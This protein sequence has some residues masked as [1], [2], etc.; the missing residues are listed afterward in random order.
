MAKLQH[1]FVRGK[2]NKDLDERLVPNGQYRDASNVQ[3]STSEG[4][5][6]GSVENILGNTIKNIKSIGTPNVLWPA[7]FGMQQ[8]PTCI[9][10]VKDSQNEKIYWF[11]ANE[12]D[13]AVPTS[14]IVEFDQVTGIVAPVLVDVNGV[15]NFNKLSLI[16]GVNILGG[17]LFFTDNLSEPKKI[18]IETFKAGSTNFT[19]QTNVYSRQF[20]LSDVTVILKSPSVATSVLTEASLVGGNGTGVTPVATGSINFNTG[21]GGLYPKPVGTVV[22]L[23][24]APFVAPSVNFN[25]KLVRLTTFVTNIDNTVDEYEVTGTL[26]NL[27]APEQPGQ[28]TEGDL[29]IVSIDSDVPNLGVAWSMLLVEE[30][31]IFQNNFPR[32]SY[33]WKYVDGEYSTYAP[34]SEAAFIGNE[35]DYSSTNAFNKGMANFTRR[36]TLSNFEPTPDNVIAVE[37]LYKGVASTNVYNLETFK[38]A[39]GVLTSFVITTELLG[40][41]IESLQL[42][43]PWDNVPRKAKSQEVIGNRIVYGNY[44]QNQTLT[45]TTQISANQTNTAHAANLLGEKSVKSNRTYQIGVAFIDEFN[46]ESPVFTNKNAAVNISQDKSASKNVLKASVTSSAP[47]WADFYKYYIKD[48]APEYYNLVLDRFYDA[49]DGNI[50]LSFPS[51]EIN[52]IR[53]DGYIFL[54]KKHGNS[55][56]V[57]E[58]NKYKILDISN[59]APGFI[60]DLPTVVA[61]TNM[62]PVTS[63]FVL[64]NALIKFN[65]A[66]AAEIS[67]FHNAINSADSIQ[68]TKGNESTQRYNIVS[69]GATGAIDTTPSPN[70]AK[71]E[72]TLDQGIDDTDSWIAASG[73][74]APVSVILYKNINNNLPE[75][76]GRFFVKIPRNAAF[77]NNVELPSQNTGTFRIAYQT[78][79]NRLKNNMPP[80]LTVSTFSDFVAFGDTTSSRPVAAPTDGSATFTIISTRSPVPA[81]T[82]AFTF[83]NVEIGASIRFIQSGNIGEVYTV[84]NVVSTTYQRT[85]GSVNVF[86]FEQKVVTLDRVYNDQFPSVPTRMQVLNIDGTGTFVTRNSAIFE[87]EPA[88]LADLDIYYEASDALAIGGLASNVNLDWFNCYSFGNG[89]ESN[90]IRDDFNAPTIGKGVRVSSTLDVPYEEER[91]ASSL[92]FSGIFNSISGVNNT[93]QFLTAENITKDLNPTYG[94]IQKLHA[95]DTDLIALLEDKCFK[96]LANKDALFNADGSTNVTSNSNVLGQTIPFVGEYGISKNPESFASFGFRTYFVDKARGTVLRLSRDGITDIGGKDMSFYFQDKLRK[97][98]STSIGSYDVDASS[99]NVCINVPTVGSESNKTEGV[100]FKESVDGWNST[101][102]YVPEAGIS[103]NN[104]YYTFKNGELYEHSNQTR[105][106]FYGTQYDS[107]V[108]PIFNDAP[109]SIKNFKTLSYEGTE[110]WTADVTTNLQEGEVTDWKKRESLF[111]NFIKGKA[112]TLANIDTE[113]FA[114]QGLGNAGTITRNSN[115]L[116]IAIAGGI[117]SSL[118]V[119]TLSPPGGETSAPDTIYYLDGNTIAILGPCVEITA[120][121]I[122]VNIPAGATGVGNDDFIFFGKNTQ[123]NTS[124]LLGH[125]ATVKMTTTSG[126]KK[127]L[128]AVNSEV[129]ISSE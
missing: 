75:F 31:P 60:S 21:T 120:T 18:N 100:S 121:T 53:E 3:V 123:I 107:T 125:Q 93:N 23:T 42:L 52:K 99:Y 72:V 84:A 113:E 43:R 97:S 4:S 79:D 37:V 62:T 85:A 33:R 56:P 54:K 111:F 94:S 12:P 10:V 14:A 106:N 59:E 112:T 91:K 24:W 78:G 38:V 70:L 51:S 45:T 15:L 126:A 73:L 102:S 74:S 86:N 2:M 28:F 124:G 105:S 46:R 48:A 88:D 71:F 117:N 98:I 32:F 90:R 66:E 11:L 30:E 22:P 5:D 104:E 57:F 92:I 114:V 8:V 101:L 61:N 119:N 118:Q 6:V 80:T 108:T 63:G 47:G 82:T 128:F 1:T 116:T 67:E 83:D 89:V 19:T 87:T 81:T 9:G 58:Q 65:A 50:W 103:L 34:F 26:S 13:G 49:E 55:D 127:E 25:G 69:G 109:T 76:Q 20:I 39:D 17:L 122:K 29:T 110:G 95:R 44:L 41:V 77:L 35:F 40:S 129:F 96:I 7:K 16:T 36:I 64:G 68:F 27:V 115:V